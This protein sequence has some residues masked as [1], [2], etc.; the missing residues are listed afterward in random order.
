MHTFIEQQPADK[1]AVADQP[2]QSV[3]SFCK[4]EGWSEPQL[5]NGAWWAYP[6]NAVMPIPVPALK[7]FD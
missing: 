4:R 7:S 2:P 5:V 1:E 3:R 6:P